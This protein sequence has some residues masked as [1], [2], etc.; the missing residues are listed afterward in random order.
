[1][2]NFTSLCFLAMVGVIVVL[3]IQGMAGILVKEEVVF[4]RGIGIS[5]EKTYASGKVNKTFVNA[6]RLRNIIVFEHL[7]TY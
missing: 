5:I 4:L 3:Y 2:I 6:Q 7:T 1:M